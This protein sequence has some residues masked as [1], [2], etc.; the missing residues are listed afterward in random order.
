[1]YD[2]GFVFMVTAVLVGY[3]KPYK[4]TYM[5]ILDTGPAF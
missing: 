1:M 5:N 3:L 4:K 2:L